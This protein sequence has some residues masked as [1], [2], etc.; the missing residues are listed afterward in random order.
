MR[1]VTFTFAGGLST[2]RNSARPGAKDKTS[3]R[4]VASMA[5]Q[6]RTIHAIFGKQADAVVAL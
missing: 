5:E 4:S 1:I 2:E 6:R 3:F